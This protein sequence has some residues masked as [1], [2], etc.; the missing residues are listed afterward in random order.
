MESKN[1]GKEKEK[2]PLFV[3]SLV[4]LGNRRQSTEMPF[5]IKSN[6]SK[7][8]ITQWNDPKLKVGPVSHIVQ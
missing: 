3:D 1:T 7:V 6:R 2:L 8:A 4:Y 5:Q